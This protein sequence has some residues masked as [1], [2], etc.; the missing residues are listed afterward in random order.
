MSKNTRFWHYWNGAFVKL[1]LKPGQKVSME[2]WRRTEEGF[3]SRAATIRLCPESGELQ[4]NSYMDARDCDG[5]ISSESYLVATEFF[6]QKD[7]DGTMVKTPV[8]NEKR[9][10]IQDVYAQMMGY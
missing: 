3:D 6:E 4:M 10:S 8:W 1:T 7:D 2:S 5:P 9:H